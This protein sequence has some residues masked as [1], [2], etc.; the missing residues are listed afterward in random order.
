MSLKWLDQLGTRPYR[1]FAR[2]GSTNDAALAWAADGAPA[3]AVVVADEQT[4]GRG[5]LGRTW[6][7]A[8]GSSLLFS[9][10]LR[11]ALAPEA[12]PRVALMG[13]V[14][15][16]EVLETMGL[17]VSVKWPNDVLVG[18]RKAA[19]ILGEA[20]W[21]GDRLA[22]VVLGIGVNICRGALP[23]A[24]ERPFEATTL[25]DELGDE[26]DRGEIFLRLLNRLDYWADRQ[27]D[28]ALLAQWRKISATLGRRITVTG[29]GDRWS[30][31]AEDI[32]EQGALLLRLENG[33]RRRV[34]AGDVTLRE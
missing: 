16:A 3:G 11:P 1:A 4:A 21:A 12:M 34:L 28:P 20:T 29:D 23:P 24:G 22:A 18:G 14:G 2:I 10:I 5:R 17:P 9:M 33:D 19:G 25:E 26:P 31:I 8:P 30:G 13:A 32:D 6:V 15:L 27:E 7:A